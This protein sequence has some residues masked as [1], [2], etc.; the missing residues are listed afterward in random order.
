MSNEECLKQVDEAKAVLLADP[1]DRRKMTGVFTSQ[2][3]LSKY[4][5]KDNTP[6]NAKYLGYLDARELYPDLKPMSFVSFVDELLD[7]KTT[8][9]YANLF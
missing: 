4:V 3:I 8:R 9:P 7:G 6:E 2:Y 5:R 1:T